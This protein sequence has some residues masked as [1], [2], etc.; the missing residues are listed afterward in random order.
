MDALPFV[1]AFYDITILGKSSLFLLSN[2]ASKLRRINPGFPFLRHIHHAGTVQV[3]VPQSGGGMHIRQMHIVVRVFS[4]VD[5]L[6]DT[7][8]AALGVL[9]GGVQLCDLGGV[10]LAQPGSKEIQLVHVGGQHHIVRQRKAL[11]LRVGIPIDKKILRIVGGNA[12]LPQG[13]LQLFRCSR[14]IQP[15][16]ILA[17]FI[18]LAVM[19]LDRKY[20]VHA[21]TPFFVLFHQTLHQLV[22]LNAHVAVIYIRV[23][24]LV[25]IGA[26]I[27]RQPRFMG[28]GPRF[29]QYLRG[30]HIVV[31]LHKRGDIT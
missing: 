4:K 16:A 5:D 14:H 1:A 17:L 10:K 21:L 26:L 11:A 25:V 30:Q 6:A 27:K 23:D 20:F 13:R 18:E 31:G 12:D 3:V 19:E 22:V 9:Q 29:L 28:L 15:D 8:K 2:V 24:V 7:R